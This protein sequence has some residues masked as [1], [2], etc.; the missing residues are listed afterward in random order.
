MLLEMYHLTI[1]EKAHQDL[2]LATLED[3]LAQ[4]ATRIQ[5]QWS[6]HAMGKSGLH[7][8]GR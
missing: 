4:F 5:P 7:K 3:Q 2:A 6:H 8:V 1:R